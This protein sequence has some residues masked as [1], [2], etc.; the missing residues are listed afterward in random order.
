MAGRAPTIRDVASRAGV[1][2]ATASNVT[3]NRPSGSEPRSVVAAIAA[4]GYRLDRSASALRGKSTRLVGGRSDITNVFFASLVHGVEALAERMARSLSSPRA[5]MRQRA[6][7]H[8]GAGRAP[9]RRPDSRTRQRRLDGRGQRRAPATASPAV[10]VDRGDRRLDLTPCAPIERRRL[11]RSPHLIDLGHRDIAVSPIQTGR[12]IRRRRRRPAR[13]RRSRA[14]AAG[15]SST[16]A[17]TWNPCVARSSLK[18][19][20]AD[21]PT[22]IF[23]SPTSA[24]WPR[25]RPRAGSI[26]SS[27]TDVSSLAS[28]ISTGCSRCGPI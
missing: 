12:D 17:M 27:R 25:S 8:R 21:R 10:L 20:R 19:Y 26:L 28:T 13:P 5:K 23:A 1:S 3:G 18:L 9:D 14:Q 2:V 16:A 4:F 15:P 24:R 22:A 11:R 6:P 7:P